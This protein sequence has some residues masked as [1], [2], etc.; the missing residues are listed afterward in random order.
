[1][2]H[3]DDGKLMGY[4]VRLYEDGPTYAWTMAVRIGACSSD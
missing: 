1:V 2:L 4:I 3:R